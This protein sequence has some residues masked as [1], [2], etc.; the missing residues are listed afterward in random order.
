MKKRVLQLIFCFG[1]ILLLSGCAFKSAHD[2]FALPELPEDYKQLQVKLDEVMRELNAEYTAPLSGSN[3]A[4]VQLQDLN[5][6]GI[7][8]STIAFFRVNS[9]ENPL[10]IMI[11]RQRTDGAYEVDYTLSGDGAAIE[12]I[13]YIDLDGDGMKDILVSWQISSQIHALTAYQL[14]KND[15][16]VLVHLSYNDSYS[17]FDLDRDNQQELMVVQMDESSPDTNRVE[18]YDLES[19]QMVLAATAP[20]SRGAEAVSPDG[21]RTGYLR[22]NIPALYVDLICGEASVTDIFAVRDG[23][24]TNISLNPITK[25][26]TETMRFYTDVATQDINNDGIIELPKP[27]Q[28]TEFNSDYSSPFWLIN[29]R[30]FDIN[31][32][33]YTVQYNYHNL[34]DGW[35]LNI[36]DRWIGQVVLSRDDSRSAWGERAVLFSLWDGTDNDP[37]EFLRIYRLS[38]T[39]GR[40]RAQSGNRFILVEENSVIYAASFSDIGWNSGLSRDNLIDYFS[41]IRTPWYNQ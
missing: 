37:Q 15:A 10:R 29:W 9:S 36:P 20:I 38:G 3:T 11:F 5:N 12:S 17:L 16:I 26:S 23:K 22:E 28:T 32:N 6:D 31:G 13:S 4:T 35:Y 24:F 41:I 14:S 25:V 2:L 8:E 1:L 30:Q 34:T 21:V 27:T 40:N 7:A 39:N 18:F 19:S 33:A